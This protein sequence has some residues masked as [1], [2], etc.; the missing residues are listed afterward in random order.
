ML[1]LIDNYD[2]FAHNLAR[3]F[4]R[5]GQETHV[6]RNDAVDV[7]AVRSIGPAAIVISPGPCTPRE[8]GSSLEIAR[9]LHAEIPMLGVCLGHQVIAEALGAQIVRASVPVHGHASFIEH[10]RSGIFEG[11]PYPFAAGRYHSLVVNPESLPRSLR[12]TAWT[13]DRDLMAFQHVWLPVFGVQFHPESI[14]T[15]R[16]YDLLANFLR[17]AGLKVSESPEFL[18][19]S[20]LA[21]A[22]QEGR[23]LP[24]RPV[25]F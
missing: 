16:G 7:D 14:L 18:A 9:E 13:E 12:A 5:L 21:R 2:S 10:H 15:D 11:L 22:D 4:T 1:L 24:S 8:A 20:E 6:V 17:L 3:Y 19:T 25:T 23:P